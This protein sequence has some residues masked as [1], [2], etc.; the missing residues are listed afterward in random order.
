MS[1]INRRKFFL[2]GTGGLAAWAAW[3]APGSD[4]TGRGQAEAADRPGAKIQLP[5]AH[6]DGETSFEKAVKNRRTRRSYGPEP[7][8]L[9][10]LSQLLW[11][12]Q[13][14][15]QPDGFKRAAP[16]AGALYPMDLYVATASGGAQ[17]LKAGV[18]HYLP[19]EHAL[20]LIEAGDKL[21]DAARAALSQMWMAKA[22]VIFIITAEYERV[23]VKY[24]RRGVRY[25]LIEAGCISQNLF[26]QGQALGLSVGI[27]GAFDDESLARSLS[28][29]PKHEPLL[30]MPVGRP[31]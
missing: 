25:A 7:L 23:T 21:N 22:G 8:T 31:G 1:N 5:N 9:A 2:T 26:L 14:L 30:A 20:T 27:V 24:G 28:L 29:A 17:D 6:P 3:A 18:Y 13:G 12:G 10:E 16:S 4:R 19:S 15:T 11:A